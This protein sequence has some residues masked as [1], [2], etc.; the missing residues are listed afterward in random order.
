MTEIKIAGYLQGYLPK[1]ARDELIAAVRERFA[2]GDE[3]EAVLR[4]LGIEQMRESAK[5]T[6]ALAVKGD[7]MRRRTISEARHIPMGLG[8]AGNRPDR[9]GGE[10]VLC[11]KGSPISIHS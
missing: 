1:T 2:P 8:K 3:R 4:D 9:Y 11:S 6:K 5:A 10:V 7:S